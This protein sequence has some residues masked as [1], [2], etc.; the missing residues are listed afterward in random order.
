MST[1]HT[2][3]NRSSDDSRIFAQLHH[4][5]PTCYNGAPTFTA[6]LPYPTQYRKA[7]NLNPK[8]KGWEAHLL[9]PIDRSQFNYLP[10]P[11]TR[12]TN[13]PKQHPYLISHFATMHWTHRP[14]DWLEGMFDDYRPLSLYREHRGLTTS[15]Q[16]RTFLGYVTHAIRHLYVMLDFL[17]KFLH[18]TRHE[19]G[20]IGDGL[21]SQLLG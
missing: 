6:K 4:K 2:T 17:V 19:I 5:L 3:P 16:T 10:H 8:G 20:H 12:L 14:T 21:W 11:W 15:V 1:P 18:P 13:H 9:G 7:S